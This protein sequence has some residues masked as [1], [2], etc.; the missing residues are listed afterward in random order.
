ML[1]A[2]MLNKNPYDRLALVEFWSVCRLMHSLCL[3]ST[4]Q[5]IW[6]GCYKYKVQQQNYEIILKQHIH[7]QLPISNRVNQFKMPFGSSLWI[8]EYAPLNL[9]FQP[10]V[11]YEFYTSLFAEFVWLVSSGL[12]ELIKALKWTLL[13]PD[14]FNI[15]TDLSHSAFWRSS[16]TWRVYHVVIRK[17]YIY[18]M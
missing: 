11:K 17:T 18:I 15:S 8:L 16:F 13:F 4:Q 3:H 14:L 7:A 1:L 6:F 2:P 9:F 5:N 10:R 12:F